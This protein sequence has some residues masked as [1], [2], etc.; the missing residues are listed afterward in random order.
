MKTRNRPRLAPKF[1]TA[2]VLLAASLTVWAGPPFRTDDPEAVEYQH[3]EFYVF[4]QQTLAADGRTGVVPAF[5]FNYGVYEKIQLHLVAPVAFSTPSGQDT[6]RGYGDTELGVKWQF[7]EETETIPMIGIFPLVE[8]P[9]GNSDKGLGNG[10]TQVFIPL[11]LQKHWGDFQTYGG[12]G[13]WIN[14]GPDN[15][16]YWFLGWQAQYQFSDHITLGAEVFHT[17]GQVVG[18]GSSTGFNVGGYY[19]F[20]EHNHLLFSAGK[21]LQNSAETNR[22]SSYLGYQYTF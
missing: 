17:T 4:Y 15:R 3:A 11:W 7:N 8:I 1:L 9:T 13:Y 5:E 19:N 22:V 16:N 14:N 10:H 20:D 6:T 18:Q 12:G 2:V 21:G